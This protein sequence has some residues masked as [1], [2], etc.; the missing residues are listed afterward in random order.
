MNRFFYSI[1]EGD[2]ADVQQGLKLFQ[3][4]RGWRAC[5]AVLN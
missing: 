3:S 1:K 2:D 5:L 4:E